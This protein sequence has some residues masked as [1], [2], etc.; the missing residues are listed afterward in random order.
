MDRKEFLEILC[1]TRKQFR[2]RVEGH[3]FSK[4]EILGTYVTFRWSLITA[5]AKAKIGQDFPLV[6]WED[7]AN[8]I[9]LS[10]ED[11]LEIERA[12]AALGSDYEGNVYIPY[13]DLSLR[14]ELLKALGLK[15]VV[16]VPDAAEIEKRRKLDAAQREAEV[17][18]IFPTAIG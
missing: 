3:G 8:A 4:G 9:G 18:E 16:V 2:W 12:G 6:K 13:Y 11:A 10:K 14:V 1:K 15:E 17:L 5:V 7:A